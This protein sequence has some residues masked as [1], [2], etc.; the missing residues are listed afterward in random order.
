M[1]LV[2]D[3]NEFKAKCLTTDKKLHSEYKNN[4]F[5]IHVHCLEENLDIEKKKTFDQSISQTRF[6]VCM[7]FRSA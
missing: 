3:V 7:T 1:S 4:N 6:I 2:A 5:L